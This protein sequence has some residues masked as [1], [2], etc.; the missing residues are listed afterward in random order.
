MSEDAQVLPGDAPPVARV[1]TS[2][3]AARV[4]AAILDAIF[5]GRFEERLP[6]E[7]EL[8]KML[9]V[10]RTTVRAALQTLERDGVVT[11]R[12]AIG[13]TINGH[14]SP[15]TLALQRLVNWEWFLQLANEGRDV[16][17]KVSWERRS[18]PSAFADAFELDPDGTC[19][20]VERS[21]LVNRGVVLHS[22][23][24]VP[25]ENLLDKEIVEPFPDLIIDFGDM[26]CKQSIDHSVARILAVAIS[27][28][29]EG[30]TQLPLDPGSAF[31]RLQETLYSRTGD[32]VGYGILDIDDRFLRLEIFRRRDGG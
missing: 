19:V 11:R 9:N 21:Y 31:T 20:L 12:R 29:G 23:A 13:T 6:A 30:R 18:I 3:L 24:V 15:S 17:R 8:A 16:D 5:T 26:Y 14:V 28:E 7:A 32:V 22:R 25:V 2:L 1:E 4:H 10:S 27:D